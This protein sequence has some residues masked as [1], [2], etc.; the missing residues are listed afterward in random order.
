[1]LETLYALNLR[2]EG[3]NCE[4]VWNVKDGFVSEGM[5]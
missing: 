4:W 1:M 3:G 5:P 2:K